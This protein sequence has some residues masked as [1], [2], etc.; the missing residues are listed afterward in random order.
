MIVLDTHAWLWWLSAPNRLSRTAARAIERAHWIG[1]SAASVYE[2]TYL[3][4]RRR[5]RLDTPVRRWVRDG[6]GR[7]GVEPLTVDAEI[8]LDAAQ[9]RVVADP[10][11]RIIYATA[12]AHDAQLVTRDN[13]L[14]SLDATRTVW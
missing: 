2:L 6:L 4:E 10:F 14:R 13:R 9:L 5:L 12:V 1:I 8:A 3:V 7:A 11:D